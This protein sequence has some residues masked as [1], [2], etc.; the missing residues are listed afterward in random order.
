V[1]QLSHE[2]TLRYSR[3]LILPEVGVAGQ[4]R[5][6]RT[7]VVVVGAG[8][9]GSPAAL[10]LAAAGVGTLGLVDFDVVDETNLQ[11]QVIHGTGGL[12]TSK[13]QSAAAR[14]AELN[15]HVHLELFDRR[16]TSG[17]AMDI[18]REFDLVVDGSDNFPTRYLINDACVLLGMPYVYGAIFRF[19]GQVSVFAASGGP[20]YRCL[21]RDPP[22]PGLVPSCDEAGVLGVLPGVIGSI[23]GLEAIKLILGQGE[24]LVGR[25]LLFEALRSEFRELAVRRDPACPVCGDRPTVHQLIDYDAFCGAGVQPPPDETLEVSVERVAREVTENPELLLVDV[26]EPPEWEVCR[27]AG[28]VLIPLG[29]L[30]ERLEELDRGREVVTVCHHGN[31][32]L[33]AVEL[34]KRRGF[35]KVRSMRGGLAAWAD[36][37]DPAMPRY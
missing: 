6:K 2:E 30:G 36:E 15:P 7:R 4:E 26:R 33:R 22:P 14:L 31:R 21:F 37:V 17:N 13:V 16:L 10:Y 29:Q 35:P 24:T 3:H 27:I 8:G 23:Q 28:S 12:G 34:L 25:L 11:R 20:C 9:L 19:S 5:L 18:L 1:T 32:S